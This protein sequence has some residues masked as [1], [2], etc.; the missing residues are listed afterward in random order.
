[1]L[2]YLLVAIGS[3]LG[4]VA[5]YGFDQ[6]VAAWLGKAFPWGTIAINI[7]GSFVIGFFAN[8]TAPTGR[9]PTGLGPRLFVMTGICGGYTTFSSFSLQTVE[10]WRRGDPLAAGANVGL[11]LVLCLLAVWLG[12][13]S[14][15][16]VNRRTP[17]PP[18]EHGLGDVARKH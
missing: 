11:S 12:H 8:L 6:A 1:M 13:A 14:A 4:G 5:R 2:G 16:A 7:L 15:A 10:L 18:V 9:W 3:A 17:L